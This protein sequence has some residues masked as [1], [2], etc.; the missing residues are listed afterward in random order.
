MPSRTLSLIRLAPAIRD[1]VP[2]VDDD[3]EPLL[4]VDLSLES[5]TIGDADVTVVINDDR[6]SRVVDESVV[7][8]EPDDE[9]A[10]GLA[11][12]KRIHG[13][14]SAKLTR[15]AMNSRHTLVRY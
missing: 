6:R 13:A 12:A 7:V 4:A 10:V 3:V 11:E 5:V 2:S 15:R 9:P 1:N 14:Q 8:S